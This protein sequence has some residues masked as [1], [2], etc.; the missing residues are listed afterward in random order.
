MLF[1]QE[2]FEEFCVPGTLA[3][4]RKHYINITRLLFSRSLLS[5]EKDSHMSH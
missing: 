4:Q 1:W 2:E 5:I 3:G